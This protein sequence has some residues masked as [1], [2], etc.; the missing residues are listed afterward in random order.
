MS[1]S[2]DKDSDLQMQDKDEKHVRDRN[3]REAFKAL[4]LCQATSA[5]GKIGQTFRCVFVWLDNV[6]LVDL[7]SFK[8]LFLS[9]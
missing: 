1:I 5:Q 6:V 4:H 8:W 2:Q 9:S 7:L 3:R